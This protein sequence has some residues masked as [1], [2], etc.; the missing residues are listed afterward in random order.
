MAIDGILRD[1]INGQPEEH[2][3]ALY[4]AMANN[5]RITLLA[6]E[7]DPETVTEWLRVEG[8]VRHTK[9]LPSSPIAEE[10]QLILRLAQIRYLRALGNVDLVIDAAPELV[11]DLYSMG[12]PYLLYINPKALA[13]LPPLETWQRLAE[14]IDETRARAAQA[15]QHEDP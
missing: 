7:T 10:E 2:G 13:E 5:Y 14:R 6:D 4:H 11:D 12:Q 8:F 15:L 3:R 9:L 1:P